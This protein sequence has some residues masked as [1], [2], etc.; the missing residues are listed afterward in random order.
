MTG[1]RANGYT[2]SMKPIL[3]MTAL[4]LALT[5]CSG[6]AEQ[7]DLLAPQRDAMERAEDVE[8]VLREAAE[9]RQRE[10]EDQEG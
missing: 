1:F 9:Q 8:R 7:A 4:A 2:G 3:L 5:A 10:L 6:D